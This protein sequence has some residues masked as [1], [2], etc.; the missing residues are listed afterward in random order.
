MDLLTILC[1]VKPVPIADFYAAGLVSLSYARLL[2]EQ[3]R[4][5]YIYLRSE[6]KGK[7]ASTL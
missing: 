2:S 5:F 1:N 3:E 7:L 6:L 4:R